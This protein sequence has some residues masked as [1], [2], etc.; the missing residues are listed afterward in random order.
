MP[1]GVVGPG[2]YAADGATFAQLAEAFAALR[3]GKADEDRKL[4]VTLNLL[5]GTSLDQRQAHLARDD[6]EARQA[7]GRV[8]AR[9]RDEVLRD[10]DL[11]GLFSL[12]ARYPIGTHCDLAEAYAL[13]SSSEQ[14]RLLEDDLRRLG[15]P[16]QKPRAKP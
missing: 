6:V 1:E 2:E 9:I 5:D 11:V 10:A 8:F 12:A 3:Y 14:R 15:V 4:M 7:L 16:G 13:A